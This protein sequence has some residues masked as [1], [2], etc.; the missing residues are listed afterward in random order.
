MWMVGYHHF[1]FLIKIFLI[2]RV[3]GLMLYKI[4]FFVLKFK[5]SF[6]KTKNQF[7]IIII[8]INIHINH[9]ARISL[10]CDIKMSLH[11]YV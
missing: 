1:F 4:D 3:L 6:S 8:I 10:I 9:L 11:K 5:S 7:I 2:K